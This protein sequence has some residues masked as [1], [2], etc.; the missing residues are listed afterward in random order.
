M[1]SS[2]WLLSSSLAIVL[3]AAACSSSPSTPK[4]SGTDTGATH[5]DA[6]TDGCAVSVN[7]AT[8]DAGS[9]WGCFQQACST[10]LTACAADCTCNTAIVGALE[11]VA[12]G[13]S[14]TTCFTTASTADTNAQNV[15]TCLVTALFGSC[16]P[17]ADGSAGQ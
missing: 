6:S 13:G 11:C 9:L 17:P 16:A 4:D 15:V 7:A 3:A 8:V 5:N 14:M 2:T 12:T 1:R 10:Q